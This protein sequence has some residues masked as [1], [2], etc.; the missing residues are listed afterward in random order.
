MAQPK[1]SALLAKRL[2]LGA[3]S[4][5]E[6]SFASTVHCVKEML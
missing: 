6:N 5:G 1:F 3:R 2:S 4:S